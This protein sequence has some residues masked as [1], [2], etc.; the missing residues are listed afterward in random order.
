[1][2]NFV[3]RR[4]STKRYYPYSG[5]GVVKRAKGNLIAS[6]QAADRATFTVNFSHPFFLSSKKVWYNP[7]TGAY[8]DATTS[9][10]AAYKE[11]WLGTYVL[12]VWDLLSK[13]ENFKAFQKMYDQC[14]IDY[15]NVKLAVT[16]SVIQTGNSQT[17]YDLYT[18][19]D[20]TG[21]SNGTFVGVPDATNNNYKG[22]AVIFDKIDEQGGVTK[23]QLNA[24]QRWKQSKSIWPKTSAEKNLINCGEI[25][26]WHDSVNTNDLYYPI[27]E[28]LRP[29]TGEWKDFL[30]TNNPCLLNE[31]VKYP[32]KPTLL[33]AAYSTNVDGTVATDKVHVT[34]T[35]RIVMTAEFSVVMTFRG[36]KGAPTI[37]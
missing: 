8:S 10:G 9:P 25:I 37:A 34:N 31:N 19:W 3:Y 23:T 7:T 12:N 15:C 30:N 2:A 32:F 28:E 17:T 18:A 4:R 21:L 14:A 24:Y 5:N 1:M 22:Y 6:K 36:L 20:R 13:A 27:K 29:A 16:N 11:C 26:D 35:N 33:V